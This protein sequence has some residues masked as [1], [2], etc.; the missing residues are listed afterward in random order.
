MLQG[1]V[2]EAA[3]AETQLLELLEGANRE[4]WESEQE[5]KQFSRQAAELYD[6]LWEA[7]EEARHWERAQVGMRR[8][9]EQAERDGAW[10]KEQAFR[11]DDEKIALHERLEWAG[12]EVD[13]LFNLLPLSEQQRQ[14]DLKEEADRREAAGKAGVVVGQAS[15]GKKK[16]RG[17][18]KSTKA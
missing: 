3:Q 13:R 1:D 7:R 2:E 8:R 16:R 9:A 18:G 12:G 17:G 11:L 14:F 6:E 10:Y 4:L 5:V 15:Q